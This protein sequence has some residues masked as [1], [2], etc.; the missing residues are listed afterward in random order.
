VILIQGK[1]YPWYNLRNNRERI[2]YIRCGPPGTGTLLHSVSIDFY[3]IIT[4][5]E[6]D[7]SRFNHVFAL[8]RALFDRFDRIF[9]PLLMELE[10][11]IVGFLVGYTFLYMRFLRETDVFGIV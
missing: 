2:L 4:P 7:I 9:R 8:F 1:Y 10:A 3:P 6:E 5:K 11:T